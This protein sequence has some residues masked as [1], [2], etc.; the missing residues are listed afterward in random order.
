MDQKLPKTHKL[1][2]KKSI[3]VLFKEGK[4]TKAFPIILVHKNDPQP[5]S[6]FKVG[7]SVSKRHFK[8]AVDRNKIKRLMRENFRKNKYL[9]AFQESN[10]QLLMFIF[11]GK[12]KPTYLEIEKALFYLSKKFKNKTTPLQNAKDLN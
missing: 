1:K 11:V 10:P 5:T 3:E 4:S 12:K 8:N 9:F 6:L 7:F 2:S